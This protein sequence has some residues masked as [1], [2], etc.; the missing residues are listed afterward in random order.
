MIAIIGLKEMLLYGTATK[1]EF[2]MVK[3]ERNSFNYKVWKTV[4]GISFVYFLL[5]FLSTFWVSAVSLNLIVYIILAVISLVE[6]ILFFTVI[7]P[8]SKLLMPLIYT[9]LFSL[10]AFG[11]VVGEVNNTDFLA[12]TFHVLLMS[13]PLVVVDKPFRIGVLELV[14][15]ILFVVLCVIFKEG[16]TRELDIY[17][18][19]TFAVLGQFVNYYMSS[20]NIKQFIIS[21]KI[22]KMSFTDDLT[23]INNRNAYEHDICKFSAKPLEENFVYLI[24]DINGLKTTN[25]SLGHDAGDEL[26]TGA[27]NCINKCFGE[28]GRT[29]RIGGDEF[30]AI[31]KTDGDTL[32][33]ITENF[34]KA[35]AEWQGKNVKKL[36]IAMGQAEYR[37]FPELSFMEISKI[38]DK[39]MYEEKSRYYSAM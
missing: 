24:F 21:K 2:D 26:I 25:D 15:S 38:A 20:R 27:A 9:M 5:M 23:D 4:T 33:D 18:V 31:I 10:F 34:R 3:K 19:I 12:V 37:E 22:K 39:R 11:I 29:Y 7:T 8:K 13:L 32:G 1:A 28:Y 35:V 30:V 16:E 14:M 36:S 6:T 17:N